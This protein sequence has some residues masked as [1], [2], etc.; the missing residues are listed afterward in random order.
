MKSAQE[1][2]EFADSQ[3]R[4]GEL[5]PAIENYLKALDL[6]PSYFNAHANLSLAY[7]DAG[8]HELAIQHGHEAIR[9]KPEMAELYSNL[10]D[11]YRLSGDL[12]NA[13]KLFG[14]AVTI[15]PELVPAH[16]NL[17]LLYAMKDEPSKGIEAFERVIALGPDDAMIAKAYIYI[18]SLLSQQGYLQE[19]IS[20]HRK[21]VSV[22]PNDPEARS[23][24][25][26]T[27]NSDPYITP[28]EIY[29]E[30]LDWEKY[31][32]PIRSVEQH[33]VVGDIDTNRRIRIGYVSAD[34]KNHAVAYFLEPLLRNHDKTR[35][36]V[37]LYC[38]NDTFDGTTDYMKTLSDHWRV[39][40]KKSDDVVF[41]LI[42]EDAIDILVD[43]SGHTSGNRLSVF[44]RKP[45]PVQVTWLG[46]PCT[47]GIR[48]ID[49]RITDGVADPEGVADNT[50]SEKLIRLQN[51]FL[52]YRGDEHIAISEQPPSLEK[53]FVTFASFNNITKLNPAIIEIWSKVLHN[54]ENSRFLLKTSAL[55]DKKGKVNCLGMFADNGIPEDRIDWHFRL[56]SKADHLNLYSE[57]DIS[58][59][60]YP[61]NGTTTTFESLWMGVPV[62]TLCGDRHVSRVGAR[63]LKAVSL[64]R[65]V[66][67][68][69]DQFVN[70]ASNLASDKAALSTYRNNLRSNL[71]QSPLCD[72]KGFAAKMENAYEKIWHDYLKSN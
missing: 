32:D 72:A 48:A 7:A 57:I 66:T 68:N 31:V 45:V 62:I 4:N 28:E 15:K 33:I 10:G 63:I 64:D 21:A 65:L 6:D 26:F 70:V 17:G 30:H 27:L 51:G 9:L 69:I 58:L 44:A 67:Q 54:V 41:K 22:S 16:F 47:T 12:D 37:F 2:K 59:D 50:N 56:P 53:G 36:D 34:L 49:Y 25:L 13:Q 46:Y 38:N 42:R 60:T 14:Q 1:Y 3:R 55:T 11:I 8:N 71:Q 29:R 35:F 40:S 5:G 19:S 39:I 61:Y 23:T 52:C 18:G 20:A 24:L 43:L